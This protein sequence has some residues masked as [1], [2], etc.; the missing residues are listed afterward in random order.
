[1]PPDTPPERVEE[2]RR[3]VEELASATQHGWGHTI[4]FGPFRKEGMLGDSY[5]QIPAMLDRW[6]WWPQDLSGQSV[7]DVGCFTGG[8]SLFL[9]HRNPEVLYAVDELPERLR[10]CDFLAEV[11]DKKC[12]RTVE[13]SLYGLSQHIPAESLDLILLSGVLYHLSDML[14]GLYVMRSLLKPGGTLVIETNGV[15]DFAHSYANFGRFYHGMWWQPSGLCVLDM[16]EFM[17]F[18]QAEVRFYRPDRCLAR[19]VR[20]DGEIPFKRGLN[21]EF[22]SLRDARPMPLEAS[23]MAPA[24]PTG[25]W[26]AAVQKVAS[27]FRPGQ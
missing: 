17:G 9:A 1:M 21:W 20:S 11:F 4:D 6:G 24:R 14:V 3:R 5:L 22:D 7:A 2:I 10:Q 26:S 27:L 23:V 25:G 18:D 13:S 16:C 8:L 12:I 15:N 19:A